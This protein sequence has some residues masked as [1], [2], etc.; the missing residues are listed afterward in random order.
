MQPDL[1]LHVEQVLARLR[2]ERELLTQVIADLERLDLGRKRSRG[3]PP[4]RL[5]VHRQIDRVRTAGA[6]DE[7]G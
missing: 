2:Q 1:A 3:R 6:G 7:I 5:N 4:G